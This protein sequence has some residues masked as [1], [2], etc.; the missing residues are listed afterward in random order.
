MC[1]Q[2]N[3]N[4]FVNS[5]FMQVKRVHSM[6]IYNYDTTNITGLKFLNKKSEPEK[7]CGV[8]MLVKLSFIRHIS[9]K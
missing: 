3:R 6:T 5:N 4:S 8:L 2:T 7:V 9:L 1:T